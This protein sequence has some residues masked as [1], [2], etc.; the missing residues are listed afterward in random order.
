MKI[1]YTRRDPDQGLFFIFDSDGP[2]GEGLFPYV[3]CPQRTGDT[4]ELAGFNI[5]KIQI[6]GMSQRRK[7]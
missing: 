1:L 4:V 5:G 6:T 7:K 3:V 2:T